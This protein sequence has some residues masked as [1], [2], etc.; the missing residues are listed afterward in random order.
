MICSKWKFLIYFLRHKA[1]NLQF[2]IF[3][4]N[5]I[6]ENGCAH[7]WDLYVV[8]NISNSYLQLPLTLNCIRYLDL[9]LLHKG[10]SVEPPKKT[11]FTPELFN[12]FYTIC[13]YTNHNHISGKR[14]KISVP[15]KNGGQITDFRFASFRFWRK[16]EKPLSQRNFSMKFGSN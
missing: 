10:G 6:N 2:G 1:K 16:F 5:F 15:F 14:N 8:L 11:T 13:L 3:K 7:A 4:I 9:P 12:Y